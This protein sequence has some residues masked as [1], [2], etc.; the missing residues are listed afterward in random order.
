MVGVRLTLFL[1]WFLLNEMWT[2]LRAAQHLAVHGRAVQRGLDAAPARDLLAA[3]AVAAAHLGG[4]KLLF[5]VSFEIEGR[6][7]AAPGPSLIMIR[8]ASII[9]NLLADTQL[10]A[11][12]G[13]GIRYVVK[14]ELE[15]I[16]LID[17]GG[18]WITTNFLQRASGDADAEIAKL[19]QLAHDVGPAESVLI[20]PEGTRATAKKIARAKEIVREKQ[21][22][23]APLAEQLV[24][25]LPPR[26][27]GPLALLEE[28]PDFDVVF[29]A[30]VGFDGFEY[31]S[32]IWAGGLIGARVRMKLWRVPASEIPR[33]GGERAAYRVALRA[34]AGDGSLGQRAARRARPCA[35]DG[36]G[37]ELGPP[38]SLCYGA[39]RDLGAQGED[40]E[41]VL[42]VGPALQALPGGDEASRAA[43]P[44]EADRQA[45]LR[46]LA[47]RD[48]G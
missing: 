36:E 1:W 27:G 6:E 21:P 2:L 3:P 42:Q 38:N 33:G 25:L 26:L 43:G 4:L 46:G 11:P 24:N 30:H 23:V 39:P 9:D 5:G 16:P 44:G 20:Y 14:R 47:R 12:L 7:V 8:H 19:R 32:D 35:D 22:A 28:A 45:Q 40:E 10:A 29:F 18:R 34:L 13:I 15:A 17:I 48:Q 41:E 31:V 37:R